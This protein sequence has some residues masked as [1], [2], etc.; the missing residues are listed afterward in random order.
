MHWSTHVQL[1]LWKLLCRIRHWWVLLLFR[2]FSCP[3]WN[4]YAKMCFVWKVTSLSALKAHPR[5]KYDV[6]RLML[7]VRN[8]LTY[9]KYRARTALLLL[10]FLSARHERSSVRSALPRFVQSP[11]CM[12]VHSVCLC[13]CVNLDSNR[14]EV[15]ESNIFASIRSECT[16]F[17]PAPGLDSNRRGGGYLNPLQIQTLQ[18]VLRLGNSWIQ[19]PPPLVW[20]HFRFKLYSMCWGWEKV[21]FKFPLPLFK[22]SL[23]IPCCFDVA[24]LW[25]PWFLLLSASSWLIV[26]P[27]LFQTVSTTHNFSQLTEHCTR[28]GT[29]FCMLNSGHL[30]MFSSK[31]HDP[32]NRGPGY[33]VFCGETGQKLRRIEDICSGRHSE[34]KKASLLCIQ[35]SGKDFLLIVCPECKNLQ[36][37]E[38][39]I[40]EIRPKTFYQAYKREHVSFG[41]VCKGEENELYLVARPY[42]QNGRPNDQNEQV[43]FT[44]DHSEYQFTEKGHVKTKVTSEITAIAFVPSQN[45]FVIHESGIN[46]ISALSAASG[47]LVWNLQDKIYDMPYLPTRFARISFRNRDAILTCSGDDKLRVFSNRDG[48]HKQDLQPQNMMEI[49]D[50]GCFDDT[51]VLLQ[52]KGNTIEFSVFKIR[53][54]YESCVWGALRQLFHA[55]VSE[56]KFHH[57]TTD[58][59]S[60]ML[61]THSQMTKKDTSCIW[62]PWKR[63]SQ[64]TWHGKLTITL[65]YH[66]IY[67][68]FKYLRHFPVVFH[69]Q[70]HEKC[71]GG[72]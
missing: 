41:P 65:L 58:P 69:D 39:D 52:E 34:R 28:E 49:S 25:R 45:L 46:K 44:L 24:C 61:K 15:F 68:G 19:L 18:H 33:Y 8:M 62:F 72:S 12:S 7:I 71:D 17:S 60:V 67:E 51:L 30:L 32:Q 40:G 66:A 29:K 43:V 38:T 63:N 4:F 37:M 26:R 56:C 57:K 3:Y 64:L 22:S 27:L 42:D 11:Q 2:Q 10:W 31:I 70:K 55:T 35:F 48:K 20:I 54:D 9:E 50:L 14:G 53:A 1:S 6:Y 59:N 5:V 16:I 47:G 36:L 23:D 13:V 21:G